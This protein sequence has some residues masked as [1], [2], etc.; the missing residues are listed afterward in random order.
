MP[1]EH[2]KHPLA[3]R[4]TDYG[5][6]AYPVSDNIGACLDVL[7]EGKLYETLSAGYPG[8]E[9]VLNL[10]HTYALI[11]QEIFWTEDETY[12]EALDAFPY[13][14]I[15]IAETRLNLRDLFHVSEIVANFFDWDPDGQ[16]PTHLTRLND[17]IKS[18]AGLFEQAAYKSAICTALENKS[19]SDF[20]ELIS[21]ANWFYGE[22]EFDL[23][24]SFAEVQP[25][26]ALDSVHWLIGMN[27][28]QR[29]RFI[30]WA[31]G[32][33]PSGLSLPASARTQEYG[34]TVTQIL[35]RVTWQHEH[36]LKPAR[37]RVDF[38]VWG[39]CSANKFEAAN[40]AY[41]LEE[42]PASQWP[43]GSQAIISG[44]YEEMEPNWT[45]F[46]SKGG[47]GSYTTH[48]ERLSSLLEK[49]ND[50]S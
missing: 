3:R 33:M 50:P 30:A 19:R 35:D 21:M 24:F 27:D 20:N 9:I 14:A 26:K 34:E 18:L 1:S 41:L 29:K 42:L 22:D 6:F 5:Q 36:T 46:K 10:A 37:D 7:Y 28:T 31:R 4:I 48:K 13:L 43:E 11:S 44:L 23:F 12:K 2:S 32:H 17:P 39:L 40:A 47:K 49:T 38:A 15:Y 45:S 25:V 8:K 16:G